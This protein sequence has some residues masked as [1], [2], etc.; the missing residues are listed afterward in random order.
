MWGHIKSIIFLP[1][2]VL[3]SAC[4]SSYVTWYSAGPIQ[5]L[6]DESELW[7][8]LEFDRLV[9]REEKLYDA[10]GTYPVGHFQ[11][12]LVFNQAGLKD[13][14]RIGS[15]DNIDG[16]TFHPNITNIFRYD[17]DF[18]L[19][20]GRSRDREESLFKWSKVAKR[21]LLLSVNDASVV[22]KEFPSSGDYGEIEEGLNKLSVMYG[23]NT[24]YADRGISDNRFSWNGNN[25]IITLLDK[26][27]TFEIKIDNDIEPIVL[28]IDKKMEFIDHKMFKQLSR[29]EAGHLKNK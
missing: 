24:Q 23:W 3:L 17:S 8:F 10:P 26:D 19:Y 27:H 7:L 15:Q 11:E 21:F 16:V 12:I 4:E 20:Y 25:F 28:T 1:L 18:Y 29:E 2:I 9:H 22:F 13:R 5:V 6:G 14:I